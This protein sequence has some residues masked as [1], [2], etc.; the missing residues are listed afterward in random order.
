MIFARYFD[1][2]PPA[3]EEHYRGKAVRVTG[4]VR[5]YRGKPQIVLESPD[6]IEVIR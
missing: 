2:F 3:P 4:L 5:Y 1:A 6:Q